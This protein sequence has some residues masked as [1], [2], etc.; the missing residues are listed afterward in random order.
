MR[1]VLTNAACG[2]PV[3]CASR[4]ASVQ[5]QL[6]SHGGLC[7]RR[8]LAD[9]LACAALVVFRLTRSV[10]AQLAQ[11]PNN[12]NKSACYTWGRN[13]TVARVTRRRIL[14]SRPSTHPA[15]KRLC[16]TMFGERRI[17]PSAAP[18]QSRQLSQ[19]R[20]FERRLDLTFGAIRRFS[21]KGRFRE[22]G[23]FTA[24]ARDSS[25]QTYTDQ[26]LTPPTMMGTTRSIS[27][28]KQLA[29]AL[30]SRTSKG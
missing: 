5:T 30:R 21:G 11:N 13:T 15:I 10:A 9:R 27:S 17:I 19:A 8:L 24:I 22:R 18:R 2:C 14:P 28:R 4:E 12:R 26:A 1:K 3:R 7:R 16:S 25:A 29:G 20:I 6:G 23:T